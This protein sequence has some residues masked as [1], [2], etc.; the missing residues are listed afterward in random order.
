MLI[1]T[2][3][4]VGDTVSLKLTSGEEVI[5]RLEE[6]KDDAYV[7]HKPMGL[8]DGQQGIGMAPFMFS[9]AHD[10]KY[11]LQSRAVTC[12]AKTAK[13]LASQYV[14]QTTGIKV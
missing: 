11:N 1:E 3:Y 12:I 8:V 10:G 6:E 13:E 5:A 9:V 7:L 4:K 2:P 14:E